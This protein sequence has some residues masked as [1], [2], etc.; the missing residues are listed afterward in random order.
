[1]EPIQRVLGPRGTLDNVA[2]AARTAPV[3]RDERDHDRDRRDRERD[4]R[5]P[6]A[7]PRDQ[8]VHQDDDGRPHVDVRA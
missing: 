1:M 4:R 2:A 7:D 5:R 6:A 3:A 8:T